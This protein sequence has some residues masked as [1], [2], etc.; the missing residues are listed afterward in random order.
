MPK[1]GNKLLLIKVGVRWRYDR[2]KKRTLISLRIY[3]Q[4]TTIKRYPNVA[5]IATDVNHNRQTPFP[6]PSH[7]PL[8]SFWSPTLQAMLLFKRWGWNLH[9][10]PTLHTKSWW[11]HQLMHLYYAMTR[12]WCMVFRGIL[13][14]SLIFVVSN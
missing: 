3:I 9:L 1:A 2:T 11:L 10:T 8:L 5:R 14:N 7:P 6:P 4:R 12:F 13:N